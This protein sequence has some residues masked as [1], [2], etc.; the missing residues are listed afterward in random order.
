MLKD[1]WD[2]TWYI[3]IIWN[4]FDKTYRQLSSCIETFVFHTPGEPIRTEQIDTVSTEK[5]DA[6]LDSK[7]CI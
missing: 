6:G 7:H 3:M 4:Q 5:V 2:P 1:N